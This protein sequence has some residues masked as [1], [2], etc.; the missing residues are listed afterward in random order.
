MTIP[1]NPRRY[2]ETH[3][4]T[5]SREQ[6]LVMLYDG[7]LRFCEQGKEALAG[8]R[9]EESHEALVRAQRIVVELWCALDPAQDAELAKRLGGLYAFL[10]LRLVHANVHRDVVAVEDA[11][12]VLGTLR[13]AWAEAADK[14]RKGESPADGAPSLQLTG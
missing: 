6:L 11:V 3:I 9:L 10:Y 1:S 7:A 12:K 8:K 4:L 2:L 14:V 5:A 13:Q